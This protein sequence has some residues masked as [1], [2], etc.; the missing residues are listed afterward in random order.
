M[1]ATEIKTIDPF[2]NIPLVAVASATS[3]NSGGTFLS[4]LRELS[5]GDGGAKVFRA[6]QQG[7]WLGADTYASAPF[8]VS[9]GGIMSAI[10]ASISGFIVVGGAA[11]DVNANTTT[12]NGGKITT[13]SITALQIQANTI[14]ASQLSFVPVNSTNVIASINASSEGITISAS[15]ILIN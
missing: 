12:I 13:G 15:K 7:I 5:V 4:A 6:D 11:S 14:T 10:G 1:S 2:T 3:D 8:K 9:M